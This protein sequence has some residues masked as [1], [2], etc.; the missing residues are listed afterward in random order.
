[1]ADKTN[2]LKFQKETYKQYINEYHSGDKRALLS[3]LRLCCINKMPVPEPFSTIISEGI[4]KWLDYEIA[5]LDE[6]LSVTHPKKTH[7]KKKKF[8]HFKQPEI[9]L[10]VKNAHEA[11]ESIGPALFEKVGKEFNIGPSS[12]RDHYYEMKN[13][14]EPVIEQLLDSYKNT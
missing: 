14:I 11:G 1:M 4:D 8:K 7:L 3:A 13:R 5:T 12:V 9:Y 10:K 2:H 6:A